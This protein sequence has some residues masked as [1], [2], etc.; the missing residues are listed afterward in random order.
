MEFLLL[1]SRFKKTSWFFN[2]EPRS[3]KSFVWDKIH[4]LMHDWCNLQF[5]QLRWSS[6]GRKDQCERNKSTRERGSD[7]PFLCFLHQISLF[8][9]FF[10]FHRAEEINLREWREESN[11]WSGLIAGSC[12]YMQSAFRNSWMNKMK[13]HTVQCHVLSYFLL[14]QPT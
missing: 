9:L 6:C 14:F 3:E 13:I 8:S 10:F 2:I 7:Y 1:S 4:L 12:I 5:L 11:F